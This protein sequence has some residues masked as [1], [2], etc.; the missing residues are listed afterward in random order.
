MTLDRSST[1]NSEV[2]QLASDRDQKPLSRRYPIAAVTTLVLICVL[3][4]LVY[5]SREFYW[6]ANYLLLEKKRDA[7]TGAVPADDVAIFGS[8]RFYH[9][10]PQ[11][12]KEVV[13]L[14]KRVTNY[15]WGWCGVEAYEA[16]LRGLINAGRLPK[17][18]VT[19][20]YPE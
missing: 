17:V 9:V 11:A 10:R 18:I 8:S 1:S 15:S 6:D 14:D 4:I 2:Q 16:M 20:S 19:D 12:I 3:E 5:T 7:L 13:G